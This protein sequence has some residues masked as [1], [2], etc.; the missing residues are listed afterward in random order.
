MV[1]RLGEN[2][3]DVHRFFSPTRRRNGGRA[4]GILLKI[5]FSE[6]LAVAP[7]T[8]M[9]QARRRFSDHVNAVIGRSVDCVVTVA[10]PPRWNRYHEASVGISDD[11][12]VVTP[13]GTASCPSPP[14]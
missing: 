12:H 9:Q 13:L 11:L 2:V 5:P 14:T 8:R 4:I 7:F 1:G 6:G 3:H 10:M